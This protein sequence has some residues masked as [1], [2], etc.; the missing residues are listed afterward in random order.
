MQAPNGDFYYFKRSQLKPGKDFTDEFWSEIIVSEVG[1]LLGFNML[2]YHVAIY[3]EVAGC[4]CKSMIVPDNEELIEV[5]KYLQDF[6]PNYNP[7]LKEH[8]KLYTFKMIEHSLEMINQKDAMKEVVKVILLDALIGNGDRHQENMTL[9]NTQEAY[10][11]FMQKIIDSPPIPEE[12]WD[13]K[14]S[15]FIENAFKSEGMEFVS[16]DGLNKVGVLKELRFSPIYDSGSS[17]GRELIEERI[18]HFLQNEKDFETYINRGKSEIHWQSGHKL[19]H[20]DLLRH[21]MVT[22]YKN[23]VIKNLQLLE[24][25]WDDE[26]IA[27]IV[28]NVDKELPETHA[29]YGIPFNRKQ[30]VLKLLTSRFKKLMT[31]LHV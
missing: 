4:I 2:A 17:L 13:N 1:S 21:I 10:L 27:T 19:S 11:N 25:Q 8:Q 24:L 5:V 30:F 3:D 6:S 16:Q 7:S 29:M 14:I 23:D 22:S 12:I 18:N 15:E 28:M 26:K 20:F 9:I 31:L